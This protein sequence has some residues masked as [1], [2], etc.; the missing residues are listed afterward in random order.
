MCYMDLPLNHFKRALKTERAQMGIWLALGNPLSAEI[1]AGAGFDWVL[2]DG[3]HGPNDVRSTLAQLQA[4]APYRSHP[5][6]R[7]VFGTTEN[8]KQLLDIGAQ[9]LLIPLVASEEQARAMVRAMRYPPE[10]VRGVGS[11]I[12]RASRWN[13]IA[14]YAHKAA[15]ELCLLV[16]IETRAGLQN[17]D[18]IARVDG[19]DGLFIGPNDLAASLGHLGEPE[20]PEVLELI[21]DAIRKIQAA[22][23]AAGVLTTSHALARHYIETGCKFVA[24][25][26]DTSL[27]AEGARAVAQMYK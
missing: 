17:L 18:A 10:G 19:V 8:V 21:D 22:G 23:K 3:E 2:I 12:A 6:V 14:D 5:I 15:A 7:P 27:L 13:A 1:C 20:H 4:V 26:A 9:T 24:I 25:A 11:A 16:Q